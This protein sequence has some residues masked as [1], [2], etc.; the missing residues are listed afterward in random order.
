M[1]T[2]NSYFKSFYSKE[3]LVLL[4]VL[5]SVLLVV[6]ISLSA[7]LVRLA[8]PFPNNPW[9]GGIVLEAWRSYQ[10]LPVY[11]DA[12]RGHATHFYGPLWPFLLGIVFQ[13]TQPNN[14]V[15]RLISLFS[16]LVIVWSLT[17]V[18]T[19]R[20]P[21]LVVLISLSLLLSIN[22]SSKYYFTEAR[23]DFIAL[24]IS[25]VAIILFYFSYRNKSLTT[26]FLG[27]FALVV[28]TYFKQVSIIFSVFPVLV[29]FLDKSKKWSK[30]VVATLPLV[31]ILFTFLC[32]HVFFPQVYYYVIDVP[33]QYPVDKQLFI[34]QLINTLPNLPLFLFCFGEWLLNR[35]KY[36]SETKYLSWILI[37]IVITVPTSILFFSKGGGTFNSLIPSLFAMYAF[38]ITRLSS[39]LQFLKNQSLPYVQRLTFSVFLSVLIVLSSFNGSPQLSYRFLLINPFG[40]G[41]FQTIHFVENLDGKVVCPEEPTIPF[42]AKKYAGRN[43]YFEQ[44]TAGWPRQI[45]SY[46]LKEITSADYVVNVLDFRHQSYTDALKESLLK[47]SGF[48]PFKTFN[49]YSIWRKKAV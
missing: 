35:N 25:W 46:V 37:A 20:E 23:P 4:P 15:G 9:E 8:T 2:K 11:E 32:L 41:Y 39:Y 47:D 21:K 28:A 10:G 40:S 36:E 38:C 42:Y 12:A 1:L 22:I 7:V 17:R 24:L 18:L 44:D 5:I 13:I 43:I 16:A 27:V 33:R 34:E 48:V 26:Y 49:R 19:V 45:P 30:L 6:T 3:R 14:Y 31:T 29:F